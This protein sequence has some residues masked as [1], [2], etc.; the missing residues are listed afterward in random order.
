MCKWYDLQTHRVHV[1]GIVQTYGTMRENSVNTLVLADVEISQD[2]VYYD[3][4]RDHVWLN[5]RTWCNPQRSQLR[6]GDIGELDDVLNQITKG[7]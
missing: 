5:G 1:R 6:H 4:A 2:G 7:W 3:Y